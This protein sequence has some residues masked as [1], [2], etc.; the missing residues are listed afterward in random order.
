MSEGLNLGPDGIVP[1]QEWIYR[2]K[3]PPSKRVLIRFSFAAWY[4]N[5][6]WI[7]SVETGS[8]LVK[9]G[10]YYDGADWVSENNSSSQYLELGIVAYRKDSPPDGTKPFHQNPMK[11]RSISP[12]HRSIVVGFQDS[13]FDTPIFGNAIAAVNILD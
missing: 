11:V 12:D 3:V 2:F 5:Q 9:R 1:K 4:E 13:Q 8:I 10:N 6:I 7:G